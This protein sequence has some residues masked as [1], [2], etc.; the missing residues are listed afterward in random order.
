M[1]LRGPMFGELR[2][3]LEIVQKTDVSKQSAN[4]V[5]GSTSH[6]PAAFLSPAADSL[7]RGLTPQ[8]SPKYTAAVTIMASPLDAPHAQSCAAAESVLVEVFGWLG[9]VAAWM[10]F[11]SPIP[12]MRKIRRRGYV[13]DFSSI[14]YL[15]SMLQCGLWSVYAL[16]PVTPCKLQPL[17]TNGVGFCLEIACARP[18]HTLRTIHTA[19]RLPRPPPPLRPTDGRAARLLWQTASS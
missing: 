10:L 3:L 13:G 2:F 18:A 19:L 7:V 11:I 1:V 6:S 5:P 15:I 8:S 16:P 4:L 9:C 12:T 17:V 14:P